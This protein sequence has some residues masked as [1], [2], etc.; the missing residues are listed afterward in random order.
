[1]LCCAVQVGAAAIEIWTM[2]DG[3]YFDAVVVSNSEAEAAEARDSSWKPKKE[4]EVRGEG[5]GLLVWLWK[6][7]VGAELFGVGGFKQARQLARH[8]LC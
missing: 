8:R 7:G 5:K 4:V 2:D 6:A 3:Y 1:M